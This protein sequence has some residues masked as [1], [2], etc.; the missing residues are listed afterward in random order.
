MGLSKKD[1]HDLDSIEGGD[2]I[3]IAEGH[4]GKP[5]FL[6]NLEEDG[7]K[8]K[9]ACDIIKHRLVPTGGDIDPGVALT[10][11]L[12]RLAKRRHEQIDMETTLGRS[13]VVILVSFGRIST[14]DRQLL[15]NSIY[16]MKSRMPEAKLIIATR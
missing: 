12:S 11:S 2:M 1:L 16:R 10:N 3:E 6:D 8:A 4:D 7:N 5:I 13:Q 14:S 9:L 15:Q